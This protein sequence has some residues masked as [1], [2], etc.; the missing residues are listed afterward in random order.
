MVKLYK[1][2]AVSLFASTAC[3]ICSDVEMVED[4]TFDN[5]KIYSP[6]TILG[7]LPGGQGVWKTTPPNNGFDLWKQGAMG[8]PSTTPEGQPTGQHLDINGNENWAQISYHYNVPCLLS[9]QEATFSFLYWYRPDWPVNQF[10]YTV[11]Q[12][13]RVIAEMEFPE[14]ENDEW[15]SHNTTF[16]IAPCEPLS[17]YF[18]CDASNMGGVH[19]DNVSLVATVCEDVEMVEG[20]DFE[21][22]QITNSW[23]VVQVLPGG[24]GIWS[25]SP[26]TD[27][28]VLWKEGALGLPASLSQHLVKAKK[29]GTES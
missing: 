9:Q 20:G 19:I 18:T 7:A 6:W 22:P 29:N 13:G 28:F 17:F 15:V 25:P 3:E 10:G 23:Q 12:E 5:P 1:L 21:D 16:D 11:E 14:Q 26:G 8:S 4:G 27:G 2:V 24:N